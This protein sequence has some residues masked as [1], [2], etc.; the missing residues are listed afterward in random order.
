MLQIDKFC[1]RLVALKVNKMGLWRR[2]IC[3]SLVYSFIPLVI[4]LIFQQ[5]SIAL[6][7]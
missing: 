4:T 1:C 7:S 6:I 5:N 2:L 3:S